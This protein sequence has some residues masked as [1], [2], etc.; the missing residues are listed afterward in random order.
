MWE[1]KG[2]EVVGVGRVWDL[3]VWERD[4]GRE[5]MV[6]MVFCVHDGWCLGELVWFDLEF[7]G[8]GLR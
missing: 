2:E 5:G 4:M 8:M 7:G 1:G 3:S 6:M